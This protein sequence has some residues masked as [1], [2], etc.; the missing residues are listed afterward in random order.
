MKIVKQDRFWCVSRITGPHHNFLR[1]AFAQDDVQQARVEIMPPI[2]DCQHA[3]LN[4]DKILA[5][6]LDG[7][8]EANE[9]F[10]TNYHVAEV[11]YPVNDTPPE[12][13]YGVLAYVIVKHI[14]GLP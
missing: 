11:Q 13:T 14:S 12:N 4:T 8:A 10:G 6:V 2:G 9:K 3:E 5:S 7:V 1:L